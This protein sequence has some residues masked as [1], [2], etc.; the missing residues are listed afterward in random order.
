MK[1]TP[2]S[3]PAAALADE[4][5]VKVRLLGG[6]HCGDDW[7]VPPSCHRFELPDGTH[8]VFCPHATA[9][10]GRDTFLHSSLD[11]FLCAR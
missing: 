8:Y 4:P 10:H 3:S 6:P 2:D 11:H 9:L 5:K 7:S 1:T